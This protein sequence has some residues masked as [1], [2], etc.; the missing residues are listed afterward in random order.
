M[1]R[2]ALL[3]PHLDDGVALAVLARAGGVPLRTSSGGWP[4]TGI[5]DWPDWAADPAPT[6]GSRALPDQLVAF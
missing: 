5:A 1:T 2:W 6:R 4:I 3:R